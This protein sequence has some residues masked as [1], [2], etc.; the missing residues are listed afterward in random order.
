MNNTYCHKSPGTPKCHHRLGIWASW[1]VSSV[2]MSTLLLITVL[3]ELACLCAA[4]RGVVLRFAQKNMVVQYNIAWHTH[5][6]SSYTVAQ[7]SMAYSCIVIAYCSIV[8]YDYTYNRNRSILM[9]TIFLKNRITCT[10]DCLF[11]QS[12]YNIQYMA[13]SAGTSLLTGACRIPEEMAQKQVSG[14]SVL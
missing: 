7:H 8:Y 11:F 10:R 5:R 6:Q 13:Q 1:V 2:L 4:G 9:S 3:P 14:V 12:A